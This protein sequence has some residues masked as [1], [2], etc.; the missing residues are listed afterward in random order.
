ME[1]FSPLELIPLRAGSLGLYKNIQSMG[2]KLVSSVLPWF[3]LGFYLQVPALTLLH[4]RLKA[5]LWS[6]LIPLQLPFA[7]FVLFITSKEKQ[8]KIVGLVFP[9]EDTS[10]GTETFRRETKSNLARRWNENL[11]SH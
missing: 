11:G 8:T 4:V 2:S 3:L 10:G 7:L 5:I 1:G 6:E 9:M